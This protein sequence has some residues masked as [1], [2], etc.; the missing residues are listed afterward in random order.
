MTTAKNSENNGT[1]FTPELLSRRGEFIAWSLSVILFAT[2]ALLTL[3]GQNVFFGLPLLAVIMLLAAGGISLGNWMDRHTRL[4]LRE[5]GIHFENGLRKT[6]FKWD[7]I[8]AVHVSRSAWGDKVRVIGERE[9]FAFRTL[10]EVK[11]NN[12]V[13]GRMGFAE[14]ADILEK[15]LENSRLQ[16]AKQKSIDQPE[17]G[18]YYIRE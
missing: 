6:D 3:L 13:K 7:E 14:G 15:I 18:D 9:H 5:D 8:Q 2:W 1:R 11:L 10:G 16:P 4:V 17:A 12:E